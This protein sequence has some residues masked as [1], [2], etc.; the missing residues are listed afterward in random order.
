MNTRLV[1]KYL[2]L[3]RKKHDFTQEDLAQKLSISRQAISKWETGNTIPD[4]E[5]LL[6]LSKLYHISIN[7]ILEPK[8]PPHIIENFEQI[9]EISEV[10]IKNILNDFNTD[11]IVKASLGASP[12]V[13]EFLTALFPDIDFEK[14]QS[15][16]G[17]IKII[18][19]EEIHNQMIAMIN[20]EITNAAI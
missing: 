18:D 9:T 17:R 14:A 19:I 20:L 15:Q 13:N 8:I 4:V 11:D 16:I 10:Y 12:A 5:T 2:Q 1:A 6:K 7:A 3:L